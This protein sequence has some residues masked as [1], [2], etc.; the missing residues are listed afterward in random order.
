MTMNQTIETLA[1]RFMSAF[2]NGMLTADPRSPVG[3]ARDL[4]GE[5]RT[6]VAVVIIR[7]ELKAMIAGAK[8]EEARRAVLNRVPLASDALFALA[9][10][11][12]LHE[13]GKSAPVR[14]TVYRND[15]SAVSVSIP[16]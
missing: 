11:E 1:D 16:E 3:K 15:G 8:Y 13:F 7:S 5:R 4:L 12:A 10:S 2:C 6:E 14:H 9:L